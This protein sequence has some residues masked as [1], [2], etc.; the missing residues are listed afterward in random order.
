VTALV[1]WGRSCV[2]SLIPTDVIDQKILSSLALVGIIGGLSKQNQQKFN[3]LHEL[4]SRLTSNEIFPQWLNK[5]YTDEVTALNNSPQWTLI[6][7]DLIH[8][9]TV[10][11]AYFFTQE[12]SLRP[13]LVHILSQ[14]EKV[15][16]IALPL[17]D[18]VPNFPPFLFDTRIIVLT[19]IVFKLAQMVFAHL[20]LPFLKNFCS[21]LSH[22][23]MLL[24]YVRFSIVALS[25]SRTIGPTAL[26]GILTDLYAKTVKFLKLGPKIEQRSI[27]MF[28][29]GLLPQ[30]LPPT[31]KFP[32]LEFSYAWSFLTTYVAA[33]LY[34]STTPQWETLFLQAETLTADINNLEPYK[35]HIQTIKNKIKKASLTD[36]QRTSLLEH[37]THKKFECLKTALEENPLPIL[38]INMQKLNELLEE[39]QQIP[40]QEEKDSLQKYLVERLGKAFS[41]QAAPLL[42]TF[43]PLTKESEKSLRSIYGEKGFL[44]KITSEKELLEISN[45]LLS[46][47]F[48][49]NL[50]WYI[51]NQSTM[52]EEQ[53]K[54]CELAICQQAKDDDIENCFTL[55]EKISPLTESLKNSTYTLP[56]LL[57]K[58]SCKEILTQENGQALIGNTA[59]ICH[60]DLTLN[61]SPLPTD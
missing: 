40:T 52:T 41:E 15:A 47:I 9:V 55:S 50:T 26:N 20:N 7:H 13:S 45:Q 5:T 59:P 39:I 21:G 1:Q 58:L 3:A 23:A 29:W 8:I 60:E 31:H 44:Q 12:L 49:H 51:K 30:I 18:Q 19:P 33:L 25:R 54:N 34:S 57:Y 16:K 6:K 36:F 4:K 17:L 61:F 37:F 38:N 24:L 35:T 32:T 42:E 11:A 28:N 14:S 22:S 53:K 27:I 43:M 48:L 2:A 10:V 56:L 46:T